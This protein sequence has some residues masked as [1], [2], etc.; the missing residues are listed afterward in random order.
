LIDSFNK[1]SPA[2][3]SLKILGNKWPVYT[4]PSAKLFNVISEVGEKTLSQKLPYA[5]MTGGTDAAELTKDY[6]NVEVA[7]FGPGNFSAHQE[8][9]YI[10]IDAY[11]RFIDTYKEIVNEYLA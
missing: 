10:D 11:L 1:L 6:R 8:N 2:K 5:G 7:V 4:S 3:F 9:E